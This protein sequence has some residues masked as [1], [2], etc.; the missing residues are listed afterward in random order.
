[1]TDEANYA[2]E[3]TNV[4][5]FDRIIGYS[6][7]KKELMR[8]ADALKNREAY[9]RLGVSAPRGLLLAGEPGVGKTLMATCLIEASGRRAFICRKD[10]PNGEFIRTL[11]AIFEEAAGCAPSIVLL[12]DMDKF[13]NGDVSRRD[14]EEY[15]AVQACIDGIRGMDVFVLATVNDTR[16]LP[17][18]LLRA[19]RFDRIMRIHAPRD[20]D[21]EQ[22]IAHYLGGKRFVGKMDAA[23][24]ARI[25]AGRSCA[26]LET[27][28]NEAGMFA[29]FERSGEIGMEHFMAACMKTVF[30][31]SDDPEPEDDD[32]EYWLALPGSS[33][34]SRACT[35]IHEAGHAVVAE[36]L[37]PGSVTLVC[38]RG[39]GFEKG[40]FTSCTA[41]GRETPRQL[42]ERRILGALGGMAA[43]ELV[44]GAPD[45]GCASDLDDAFSIVRKLVC[46]LC[47]K[48]FQF[49]ST[50]DDSPELQAR[51]EQLI[52][53]EVEGYYRRAKQLL[54]ENREFL[55]KTAAALRRKGLL[56]MLDLRAIRRECA[57]LMEAG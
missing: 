45:L 41:V 29:G 1:M 9:E 38:A 23:L 52:A 47:A 42:T 25:M 55:D 31:V 26:E 24:I 22:I 43:E 34:C 4:K 19:G 51:Q 2:T 27:V 12:D 44:L 5:E 17:R 13:A 21:A 56:T 50:G 3:E 8:I 48:G 10:Q 30:N 57:C 35:V 11:K 46:D 16:A 54:H 20:A 15:V 14:A 32:D 6:E 36:L 40:G 18:S 7:E 28:I 39:N 33:A 53:A 37:S 49:Y